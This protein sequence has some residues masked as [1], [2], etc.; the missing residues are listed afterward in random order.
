MGTEKMLPNGKITPC[1]RL[2]N[3]VIRTLAKLDFLRRIT[4]F[5]LKPIFRVS[6]I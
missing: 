1:A 6:H 5:H 4:I 2:N 3:S